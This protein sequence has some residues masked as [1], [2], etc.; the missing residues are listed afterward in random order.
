[1]RHRLGGFRAVRRS[2]SGAPR[3]IAGTVGSLAI[4]RFLPPVCFQ[5]IPLALLPP[6]LNDNNP[7]TLAR[8]TDG[9]T[10]RSAG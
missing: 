9:S 6:A 3:P 5:N 7:R 1:M 4:G 10:Q 2:G 8:R